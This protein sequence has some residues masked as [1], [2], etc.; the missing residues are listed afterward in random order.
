[1]DI[2]DK[3][4]RSH[5]IVPTELSE[6]WTSQQFDFIEQWNQNENKLLLNL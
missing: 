4:E 5:F 6:M 1:M 2:L 3:I